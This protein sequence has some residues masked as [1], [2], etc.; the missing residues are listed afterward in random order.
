MKRKEIFKVTLFYVVSFFSIFALMGAVFELYGYGRE[1]FLKVLGMVALLALLFGYL[2]S[3]LALEPLF[4]TNSLL[5]RLLKD[6]LH[7]LNLPLSTI[8]ANLSMLKKKEQDP[9]RLG[10]LERMEK[11]AG[12]LHELYFDIDYYIKKEIGTVESESFDL[13]E[14]IR[15]SLAKFDALRGSV[16]LQYAPG[17]LPVI[18]DRRG[19]EKCLDNLIQN[20]IKYN[21]PEGFVQVGLQATRLFVQDSGSGMD[22]YTLLHIFDRYYQA[23]ESRSGYGIG[24]HIVKN[25]CDLNHIEITIHSKPGEGTTFWLDFKKAVERGS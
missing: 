4:V 11:A 22:E 15:K 17:S 14:V 18:S 21:K 6:T 25:Y 16:T 2:L 9:K 3:K 7:E 10:R 19:C 23:D 20:A 12:N 1:N 5:D 13:D 8:V 24:M